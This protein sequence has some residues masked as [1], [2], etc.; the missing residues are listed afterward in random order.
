M[1]L[2]CV[3]SPATFLTNIC[4][5]CDDS[6]EGDDG[7]VEEGAFGDSEDILVFRSGGSCTEERYEVGG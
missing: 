2:R 6:E 5:L 4:M 3:L 1:R 7:L